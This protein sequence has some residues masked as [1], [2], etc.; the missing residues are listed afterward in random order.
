VPETLPVHHLFPIATPR[1]D[2]LARYLATRDIQTGIHYPVPLHI[3]PAF[4]ALGYQRS[5]MP[6]AEWIGKEELSLPIGP[7]MTDEQV[8]RVCEAVCDFHGGR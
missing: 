3:Q 5:A 4:A 7:F 2:E 6:V 8:N 1:R